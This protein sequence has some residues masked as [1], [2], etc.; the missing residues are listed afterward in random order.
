MLYEE[1]V[2]WWRNGIE[3]PIARYAS[4]ERINAAVILKSSVRSWLMHGLWRKVDSAWCKNCSC[5][6]HV[7][8]LWGSKKCNSKKITITLPPGVYQTEVSTN[9]I[10]EINNIQDYSDHYCHVAPLLGCELESVSISVYLCCGIILLKLDN[11]AVIVVLLTNL[12]LY[13][14]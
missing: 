11:I 8:G 10:T 12:F 2:V 4:G 5:A 14:L 3:I 9:I 6:H 1:L 7:Q 13:I